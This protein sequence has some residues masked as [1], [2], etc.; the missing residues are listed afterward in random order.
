M[1]KV[2]FELSFECVDFDRWKEAEKEEHEQKLET[3]NE[4]GERAGY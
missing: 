2:P 3:R 4:A 1:D